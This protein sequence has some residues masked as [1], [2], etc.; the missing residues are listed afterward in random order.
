[1]ASISSSSWKEYTSKKGLRRVHSTGNSY[2]EIEMQGMHNIILM[3]KDPQLQLRA[4]L[5]H[6]LCVG[7]IKLL[8]LPTLPP[9]SSVTVLTPFRR[10][11]VPRYQGSL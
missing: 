6:D 9:P 1:M 3:E 5:T 8:I 10:K 7:Y 2:Y 11:H 4:R